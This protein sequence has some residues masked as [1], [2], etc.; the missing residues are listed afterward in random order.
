MQIQEVG[1]EKCLELLAHLRLGR[2]ACAEEAQPYVVPFYFAYDDGYLYSFSTV[3]QKIWWMRGNPLVCVQTDEIVSLEEWVSLVIF[4]RYQELPDTPES[5]PE[6]DLAYGLLQRKEIW[7]EPGYSK[8]IVRGTERPMLPVYFRIQIVQITGHHTAPEPGEVVEHKAA[9]FEQAGK[10]PLRGILAEL[11]TK[12][13][14][15]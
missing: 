1:R 13:F 7:W 2:I 10:H 6:R 8:T 5:K 12:V 4:G 3:G 11:R 15:K 9:P 14:S